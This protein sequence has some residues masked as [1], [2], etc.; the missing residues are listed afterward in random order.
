MTAQRPFSILGTLWKNVEVAHRNFEMSISLH[1][2]GHAAL[3]GVGCEFLNRYQCWV[4]TRVAGPP[5]AP[6]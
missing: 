1:Q 6:S 5:T 2:L 4:E 3:P